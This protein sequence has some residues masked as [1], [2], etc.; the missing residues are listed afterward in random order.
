[1]LQSLTLSHMVLRLGLA[2]VFIWFGVDKFIHPDYWISAWMPPRITHLLD[3]VTIT[4]Q[5][6]LSGLALFELLVGISLVSGM[7]VRAF[8]G[9][10]ICFLACVLIFFGPTEV[11]VRDIGLIGGFLSL[12]FWPERRGGLL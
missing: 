1:M 9:V 6:F 8:S 3:I 11:L 5:T 10:A 4:P 2:T 12:F 7:F